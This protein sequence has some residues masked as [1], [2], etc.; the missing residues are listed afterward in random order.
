MIQFNRLKKILTMRKCTLILIALCCLSFLSKA[1]GW[2]KNFPAVDIA[3]IGTINPTSDGNY[4]VSMNASEGFGNN[5]PEGCYLVKMDIEGEILWMERFSE[6]FSNPVKIWE[7]PNGGYVVFE[8]RNNPATNNYEYFL[9]KLSSSFELTHSVPVG[10]LGNVPSDPV[11]ISNTEF[12]IGGGFVN[13]VLRKYDLALNLIGEHTTPEKI[14]DLEPTPDGSIIVTTGQSI[15]IKMSTDFQTIWE[16]SLYGTLQTNNLEAHPMEDGSVTL[17]TSIEANTIPRQLKLDATGALLWV[18]ELLPPNVSAIA[19]KQVRVSDGF[20]SSGQVYNNLEFQGNNVL[21]IKSDFEGNVVWQKSMHNRGS[22]WEFC[23][24]LVATPDDGLIGLVEFVEP[25]ISEQLYVF[26]INSEGNIYNQQLSGKVAYDQTENCDLTDAVGLANWTISVSN[27]EMT[28]YGTTDDLGHYTISVP[29]GIF[30]VTAHPPNFSWNVCENDITIGFVEDAQLV[31]DF[32]LS[33]NDACSSM[34][35]QTALPIV[36][37]CF[38]NNTYYISYCNEGTTGT[39]DAY[40]EITID[41]SLTYVSS[42]IPLTTQNENV[43]T[44]DLGEVALGACGSFNVDFML[45][46]ET[47]IGETVCISSDIFPKFECG[48]L[49]SPWEGAFIEAEV[50]C[51]SDSISF[52]IKNVGNNSMS[53]SRQ[54]IV[55]EDAIVLFQDDFQLQTQGELIEKFPANGSTLILEAMQEIGAPGDELVKVWVEG[56][57]TNQNGEIS[58]G[59]INQFS[60]GDNVP[61]TDR[62]CRRASS[63]FDPNDKQGFPLGYGEAHFIKENI[64]LEYL[65]RFQNT[66]N[67]TAFTVV[68]RDTIASELNLSSIRVG[69]ASHDYDWKIEGGNVLVCTFNQ[70]FLPDSTTNFDASNGFFKYTVEQQPDL[71]VGTIINND[72][73]IYFDFNEVVMT[74]ETLHT[75]GDD[76]IALSNQSPIIEAARINVYPNPFDDFTIFKMNDYF[77]ESGTF[78]LYDLTGKLISQQYFTGNEFL[79]HRDNLLNGNYFYKITDNKNGMINSGQ[80]S[81]Q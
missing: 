6:E 67:D 80:L 24:E 69:P 76:F 14:I 11:F 35:V 53:T 16:T 46:C 72:V 63:A 71:P 22:I 42:S 21:L 4:L 44:F 54:F 73:G 3:Y 50:D 38:D 79:F 56:C 60:L 2:L 39:S 59:F 5:L 32:V 1:Q 12:I 33:S 57:G 66:G 43:Y 74:N 62:E 30:T 49:S 52:L 36:R 68:L 65:I 41:P 81:I 58:T 18:K 7:S 51:E 45:D 48:I 8:N 13:G 37:P 40:V 28:L 25:I 26:K 29:T 34:V 70:I 20:I 78:E 75:I 61:H 23:H 27:E 64:D 55:I 19:K 9:T 10:E 31:K 47:E 77:T 15:V 17:F